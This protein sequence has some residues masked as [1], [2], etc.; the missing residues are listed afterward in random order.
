[1]AQQSFTVPRRACTYATAAYW[2]CCQSSRDHT[3]S[4]SCAA[5]NRIPGAGKRTNR[6]A[7]QFRRH[8]HRNT[9]GDAAVSEAPERSPQQWLHYAIDCART[10]YAAMV[11]RVEQDTLITDQERTE[12]LAEIARKQQALTK[13]K[14]E[15]ATAPAPQGA[16]ESTYILKMAY[17]ILKSVST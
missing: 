17:R 11:P 4:S 10:E 13:L 3:I 12:I 2:S 14:E 6:N 16:L 8:K 5:T 15:A 1:M 9:S 7:Y